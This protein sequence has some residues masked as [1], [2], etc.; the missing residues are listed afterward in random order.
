[1]FRETRTDMISLGTWGL[2][3]WPGYHRIALM[4]IMELID[5]MI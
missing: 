5:S 2:R 1:M 3:S 4:Q